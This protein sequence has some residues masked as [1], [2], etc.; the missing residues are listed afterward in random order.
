MIHFPTGRL[1][2]LSIVAVIEPNAAAGAHSFNHLLDTVR[3]W[4]GFGYRFHVL[5]H[6]HQ[7]GSITPQL[8]RDADELW[9]FGT[10]L[11]VAGTEF[12]HISDA[13]VAAISERMDAG[14]G[15]FATGDHEDIGAGL[16]A[17]IPRVRN[18]RVWSGAQAPRQLPP[19]SVDS[20][21]R[22]AWRDIIDPDPQARLPRDFDQLD[23]R[24]ATPKPV[25]VFHHADGRPHE[26]MQLP[27]RGVKS[28]RIRFLPNHKHEGLLLDLRD[29]ADVHERVA[30]DAEYQAGAIPR[31]VARS[32]RSVFDTTQDQPVDCASYPVVSAYEAPDASGWGN[33]VVDSTFHHWTDSNALRLR[34]SPAWLHVQ[35]YAIN[36]ANWLLGTA[37]RRK[38]RTAVQDYIRAT[39]D[40]GD[41][42]LAAIAAGETEAAFERLARYAGLRMS[43]QRIVADMLK[44]IL[45]IPLSGPQGR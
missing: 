4:R 42:I 40:G 28:G 32:V 41:E 16:C 12:A 39:V 31:I 44:R 37:G 9:F 21:F 11:C 15:V 34:F 27:L 38:V 19:R 25:W 26:L 22:S 3:N 45:G 23:D 7:A 13:E 5:E 10:E 18:M 30:L 8:I 43:E 33:I 17:A 1:L 20:T 36:V 24:D 6:V 29:C 35:Q 2:P 14:A